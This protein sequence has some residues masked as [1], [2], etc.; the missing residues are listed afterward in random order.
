MR[1]FVLSDV[2]FQLLLATRWTL[3]LALIAFVGGAIVG[4]IFTLMRISSMRPLKYFARFYINLFQGTPLLMQLF[5]IFFG[6]PLLLG[7]NVSA[8]TSASVAL[9]LFTSAYLADIWRGSVEAIPKEQWESG[10]SLG[11]SYLQQFRYIILPQ[12]TK[13][14]IPPTVGFSVQV[15]KNTSLTSIIGF[16]ELT[17]MGRALNNVTF[18]PLLVFGLICIIYFCINYPLSLFSKR[19]EGRFN[20]ARRS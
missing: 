19:L 13:I 10:A 2:V 8:W 14:A 15:I 12:A 7:Q 4:M 6:L 5:T 1:E 16:V 3:L 20:G 11:L 9:T 17:R 18:K